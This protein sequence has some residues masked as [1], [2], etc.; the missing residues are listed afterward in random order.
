MFARPLP[1]SQSRR[2]SVPALEAVLCVAPPRPAGLLRGLHLLDPAAGRNPA[3]PVGDQGRA[4]PPGL[5]CPGLHGPAGPAHRLDRLRGPAGRMPGSHS[6]GRRPVDDPSAASLEPGLDVPGTRALPLHP[7]AS[8]ARAPRTKKAT[9]IATNLMVFV[10]F[11]DGCETD[12]GGPHRLDSDGVVSCETPVSP[13]RQV[14]PFC[15]YG[16]RASE[17]WRRAVGSAGNP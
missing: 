11:S 10:R 2:R 9:G 3:G 16:S 8:L 6:P 13:T 17:R 1:R 7:A 15:I 14:G 4:P 5:R 12:W